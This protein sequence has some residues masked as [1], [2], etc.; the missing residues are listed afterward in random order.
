MPSALWLSILKIVQSLQKYCI[1]FSNTEFP[2]ITALQTWHTSHGHRQKEGSLTLQEFPEQMCA[3]REL[4]RKFPGEPLHVCEIG[5]NAGLSATLWLAENP[6]ANVLSFDIGR[7][8]YSFRA[9]RYLQRKY[10]NRLQVVWGDSQVTVPQF[11]Q[12]HPNYTCQIL[13]IDGGHELDVAK[14]DL[15]NFHAMADAAGHVATIDDTNCTSSWCGPVEQALAQFPPA[16]PVLKLSSQNQA[17]GCTFFVFD[18]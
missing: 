16:R 15:S 4:V 5:F 2:E 3:Y 11:Q 13:S 14:A 7:Y 6:S 12:L 10:P 18:Q 1:P 17:R 9:A 8:A